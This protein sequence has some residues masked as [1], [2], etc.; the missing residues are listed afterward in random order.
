MS[1]THVSNDLQMPTTH[2]SFVVLAAGA[3]LLAFAVGD[4]AATEVLLAVGVGLLELLSAPL[5]DWKMVFEQSESE[6]I[7]SIRSW[8]SELSLSSAIAVSFSRKSG[9]SNLSAISKKA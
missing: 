4:L 6:S 8:T 9:T 1:L 7:W 2:F 5:L 3:V